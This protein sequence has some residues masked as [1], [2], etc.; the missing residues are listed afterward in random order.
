MKKF[1]KS[2]KLPVDAEDRIHYCGSDP[3]FLVMDLNSR[4]NELIP[5]K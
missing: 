4:L 1:M 3:V 2:M 5:V